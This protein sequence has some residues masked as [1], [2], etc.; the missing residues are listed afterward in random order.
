MSE[1]S[2]GMWRLCKQVRKIIL[3]GTL[4]KI[5]NL[6]F[7]TLPFKFWMNLSPIYIIFICCW[8]KK[9]V[10]KRCPFITLEITKYKINPLV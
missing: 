8:L 4:P 3:W 1:Q 6:C 9:I 10:R 5:A 2:L 7:K